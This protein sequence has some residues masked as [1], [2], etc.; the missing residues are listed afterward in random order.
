MFK[1]DEMEV[2]ITMFVVLIEFQHKYEIIIIIC[3]HYRLFTVMQ[4]IQFNFYLI[5]YEYFSTAGIVIVIV[6]ISEVHTGI[7]RL[8]DFRLCR[9]TQLRRDR[10]AHCRGNIL[11]HPRLCRKYEVDCFKLIDLYRK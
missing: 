8:G 6:A 5:Y 9:V 3:Y 2:F 10:W 4:F 11:L 7:L 1:F